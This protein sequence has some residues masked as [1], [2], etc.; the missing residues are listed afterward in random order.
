MRLRVAVLASAIFLLL[1][2]AAPLP[3]AV[4][5]EPL[6]RSPYPEQ[7]FISEVDFDSCRAQGGK[8]SSVRFVIPGKAVTRQNSTSASARTATLI[9]AYIRVGLDARYLS[10]CPVDFPLEPI[11]PFKK[12][13]PRNFLNKSC[14]GDSQDLT[15]GGCTTGPNHSGHLT[16]LFTNSAGSHAEY[17]ELSACWSD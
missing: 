14:R 3:P 13:P 8:W 2:D 16:C 1:I 15:V 7:K 17:I 12:P 9:G 4:A 6:N 5:A 11:V 10:T